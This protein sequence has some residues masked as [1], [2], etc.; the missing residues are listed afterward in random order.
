MYVSWA[1]RAEYAEGLFAIFVATIAGNFWL[2]MIG[3][4]FA[5]VT[6]ILVIACGWAAAEFMSACTDICHY[7]SPLV[8]AQSHSRSVR[9]NWSERFQL[10]FIAERSPRM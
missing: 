6:A 2:V 3:S 10:T 5:V 9:P 4:L 1:I 7:R 8:A